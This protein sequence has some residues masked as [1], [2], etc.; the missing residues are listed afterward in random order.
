MQYRAQQTY[1]GVELEELLLDYLMYKKQRSTAQTPASVTAHNVA[2]TWPRP[3]ETPTNNGNLPPASTLPAI[4]PENG[5]GGGVLPEEDIEFMKLLY[6]ELAKRLM[7]AIE[8]VLARYENDGG[9]IY[10]ELMDRESLSL[11]VDQIIEEAQAHSTEVED[12]A[13]DMERSYWGRYRL[14][15]ALVEAL[16]LHQISARRRHRRHRNRNMLDTI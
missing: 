6:G 14:L 8:T 2:P 16:V 9:A 1:E 11:I 13:L 5:F 10:D 12:I 15:R 4:L 3:L 7:P